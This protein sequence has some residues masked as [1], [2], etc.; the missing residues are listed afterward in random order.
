MKKK[1]IEALISYLGA[2]QAAL[3]EIGEEALFG[4]SKKQR[5]AKEAYA[6][7]VAALKTEEPPAT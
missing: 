7:L 1:T 5:A 6:L 2:A 3:D 4:P